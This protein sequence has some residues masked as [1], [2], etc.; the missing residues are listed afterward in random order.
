MD[1][2]FV[3]TLAATWGCVFV[4][5]KG[6]N[7]DAPSA[8]EQISS[9][10]YDGGNRL[11]IFPE[12]TTTNGKYV[13]R[14]RSGSFVGGHPVKP[15]AI[16]YISNKFSPSWESINLLPH[17]FRLFTQIYNSVEVICLPIYYPSPEEA[18]DPRLYASNVGKQIAKALDL[19]ISEATWDDKREYHT[20][21][22]SEMKKEK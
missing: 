15:L 17:A 11:L 18:E 13:L 8:T 16:R 10:D 12:G 3:N 22:R 2:P 7:T 21:L 20:L 14:F 19:P 5:R 1:V 4:Y 9:R 6:E